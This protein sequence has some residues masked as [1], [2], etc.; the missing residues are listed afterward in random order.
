MTAA[1][2]TRTEHRL[3]QAILH[4]GTAPSETLLLAISIGRP[5]RTTSPKGWICRIRAKLK[6]DGIG[7]VLTP[8]G[9][10]LERLVPLLPLRA[11]ASY[12][13]DYR[14]RVGRPSRAKG[15]DGI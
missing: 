11:R 5:L 10:Q 6:H 1:T 13:R 12:M 15:R 7:V 3:W 9:Y 4:L 2:L 14:K 8:L